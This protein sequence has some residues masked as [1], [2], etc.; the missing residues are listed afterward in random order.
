MDALDATA[1]K[2]QM[3]LTRPPQHS[4]SR[5][6]VL[7]LNYI[8]CTGFFF[9]RGFF[10]DQPVGPGKSQYSPIPATSAT[11]KKEKTCLILPQNTKMMPRG[12]HKHY[13]QNNRNTRSTQSSTAQEQTTQKKTQEHEKHA[14]R[15]HSTA[16]AS[17]AASACR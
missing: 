2:S 8:I 3:S 5:G 11:K 6:A 7:T 4:A 14:R 12:K 17:S 15:R 9:H 1:E 13:Y 16:C 10:L